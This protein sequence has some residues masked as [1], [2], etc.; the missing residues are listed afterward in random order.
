MLTFL[1]F[2]V[3]FWSVA[4][5]WAKENY[6]IAIALIIVIAAYGFGYFHSKDHWQSPLLTKI[7]KYEKD[8][9]DFNEKLDA[10]SKEVATNLDSVKKD[11]SDKNTQIDTLS[12]MYDQERNKKPRTIYVVKDPRNDAKTVSV[13]FNTNG[14]QICNRFSDSYLE[15]LNSMINEANK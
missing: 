1:P 13:E 15:T 3:N 10:I 2:L 12:T 9:K 5:K 11:I 8:Q 6:K 14:D 4:I 7:E